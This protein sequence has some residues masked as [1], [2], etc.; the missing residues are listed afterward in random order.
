M[1]SSACVTTCILLP[2]YYYLHIT[3]CI[4]LHYYLHIIALLPAYCSAYYFSYLHTTALVHPYY[5]S[6]TSYSYL[7]CLFT[8]SI[9]LSSRPS[10]PK[11]ILRWVPHLSASYFMPLL[12]PLSLARSLARSLS[13]SLALSLSLSTCILLPAYYYLQKVALRRLPLLH[14]CDLFLLY[15][16]VWCF[17]GFCT[18]VFSPRWL[19]SWLMKE[20]ITY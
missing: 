20:K 17:F 9:I 16:L 11:N 14:L 15:G 19:A 12:P 8:E 5:A 4:L 1:T 7:S 13:R 6:P 3:T 18:R 10:T 2:A